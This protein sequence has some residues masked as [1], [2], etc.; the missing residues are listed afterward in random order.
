M[1]KRC[2]HLTEW[3]D[4]NFLLDDTNTTIKNCKACKNQISNWNSRVDEAT[5]VVFPREQV[6]FDDGLESPDDSPL[7]G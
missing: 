7:L 1:E 3:D 5:S 2:S 4:E 6:S